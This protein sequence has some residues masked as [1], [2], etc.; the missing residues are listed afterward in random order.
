MPIFKRM[1]YDF[2][3]EDTVELSALR[4][5]VLLQLPPGDNQETG[6]TC[7]ENAEGDRGFVPEGYLVPEEDPERVHAFE[8]AHERAVTETTTDSVPR[9]APPVTGPSPER[10]LD[11][12]A[13][14]S[15]GMTIPG[16]VEASA[17]LGV[18]G[19]SF[20]V[21]AHHDSH[22]S[23]VARRDTPA[24]SA[25][26]PASTRDPPQPSPG[27]AP[28]GG[29]DASRAAP[30]SDRSG[31]AVPL[32][33]PPPSTAALPAAAAPVTASVP[34]TRPAAPTT[35]AGARPTFTST[36]ASEVTAGR[37]SLGVS[38]VGES[39][40]KNEA[41][42]TSVL[43]QRAESLSKL[44]SALGDAGTELAAVR[45]RNGVLSSRV[46]ELTGLLKED[47]ARWAQQADD[48][49][50]VIQ[51]RLGDFLADCGSLALS[52]PRHN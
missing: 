38:G 28:A 42:F 50:R 22:D 45:E 4:G 6:W 27:A 48:E 25:R 18:T 44:E 12:T 19:P 8:I 40:R 49:R 15:A 41:Y 17:L 26:S 34:H 3:A 11:I 43:K 46:Q 32:P 10:Q 47:R 23:P 51:S 21:G 52:Q 29:E 30:A 1:Q 9:Q 5:T 14:S 13:S 7:V 36:P 31:T 20:T 2:S 37:F 39:F 33:P 35:P 16:T 24:S